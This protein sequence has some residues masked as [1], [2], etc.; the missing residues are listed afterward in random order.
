MKL[1][2][3]VCAEPNEYSL[4]KPNFCGHCKASL[5][6]GIAS[7]PKPQVSKP[8]PLT[9][10]NTLQ[11]QNVARLKS[12]KVEVEEDEED[13]IQL[14]DIDHLDFEIIGGER[15]KLTLGQ[16]FEQKKTGFTQRPVEKISTQEAIR[17]FQEEAKGKS[18]PIEIED[19]DE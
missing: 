1:Y 15:Q 19:S 2:C 11:S 12:R 13:D 3:P 7:T 8:Q 14:P 18:K 6:V 17:Q 16:L 10:K 5:T 9:K 4:V